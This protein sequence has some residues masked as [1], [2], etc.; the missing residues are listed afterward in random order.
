MKLL[1]DEN[2]SFKLVRLLQAEYPESSH[3]MSI[4]LGGAPDRAIWEYARDHGFMLVSKDDDFCGLSLLYGAP[5]KVIWLNL[6]NRSTVEVA[7]VL[8]SRAGE[9]AAFVASK[10]ESLLILRIG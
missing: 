8:K 7:Q 4:G 2:L 6:G 3:V 1:F 10:D 9:L 5:P